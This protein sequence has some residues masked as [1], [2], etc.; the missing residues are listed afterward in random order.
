MTP[1]EYK[2]FYKEINGIVGRLVNLHRKFTSRFKKERVTLG[3]IMR[4]L[5]KFVKEENL[6]IFE[7]EAVLKL[8]FGEDAGSFIFSV[9]LKSE[10]QIAS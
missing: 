8:T 3:E 1:E 7:V 9:Y 4:E 6:D 10:D 2:E 5:K